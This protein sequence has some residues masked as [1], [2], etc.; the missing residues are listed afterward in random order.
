MRPL[1]PLA[2]LAA[3]ALIACGDDTTTADSGRTGDSATDG[4]ATEPEPEVPPMTWSD[5]ILAHEES[6]SLG[7]GSTWTGIAADDTQVYVTLKHQNHLWLQVLDHDLNTIGD[8]VQLTFDE[9]V[10]GGQNLADHKLLR[11]GDRLYV[12]WNPNAQNDLYLIALSLEGDRIGEQV[13]VE[14]LANTSTADM[15]LTTDGG[16]LTLIYGTSGL[17]RRV[18]ELD[19]DLGVVTPPTDIETGGKIDQLGTTRY[20]DGRWHMFT[21]DETS[22]NLAVSWFEE[23]WT[24]QDPFSELLIEGEPGEWNWFPSGADRS[25]DFGIWSVVYHNMPAGGDFE[26]DATIE[27]AVFDQDLKWAQHFD[28]GGT[29]YHASDVASRGAC[30]FV[31]SA[32]GDATVDRYRIKAP[33]DW[34]G[35]APSCGAATE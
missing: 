2:G 23:D 26:N 13:A 11:L 30:V 18:A 32:W 34:T 8:R 29:D 20:Y 6:V 17:T 19:R 31:A 21:G 22:Q 33:D 16:T 35:D 14:Q 1:L 25:R 15:H 7:P 4:W 10:P 9:D 12:S 28:V 3:C 5:G 24:P 27:L